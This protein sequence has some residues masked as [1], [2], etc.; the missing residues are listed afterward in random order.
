MRKETI[1][2]KLDG[3]V[4]FEFWDKEDFVGR[5]TNLIYPGGMESM[6][7]PDDAIVCDFCNASIEEFPVPVFNGTHALCPSCYK[8]VKAGD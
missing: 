7:I 1:E 8:N 6:P 5:V 2:T 3:P 4:P